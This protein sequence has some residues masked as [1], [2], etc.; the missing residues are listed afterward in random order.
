MNRGSNR[1]WVVGLL[2]AW[3][4]SG[5]A[6]ALAGPPGARLSGTLIDAE[7]RAARG[8]TVHLIDTGGRDVAQATT[9]IAGTY[10]IGELEA[11]E[12]GMGVESPGGR[13][14]PV[15]APSVRVVAG[16]RVRRDVRLVAADARIREGALAASPSVGIW[17][18]GLTTAAKAGVIVGAVAALGLT[19]SALNESDSSPSA[20]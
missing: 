20:P 12:Y 10:A 3:S 1:L 13:M 19:V 14:A 2:L 17:W 4:L 15:A 8:Y 7:G 16:Q 11:G 9:S 6:P 18:A 5:I